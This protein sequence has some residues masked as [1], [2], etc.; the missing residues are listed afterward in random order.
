M[1]YLREIEKSVRKLEYVDWIAEHLEDY[2]FQGDVAAEVREAFVKAAASPNIYYTDC[3][4]A[5]KNMAI[6][7][8]NNPYN[9]FLDIMRWDNC[10]YASDMDGLFI[11]CSIGEADREEIIFVPVGFVKQAG[12]R[13][14]KIAEL[15]T[16]ACEVG[17]EELKK[18]LSNGIASKLKDCRSHMDYMSA[19]QEKEAGTG[20]NRLKCYESRY[21][22]ESVFYVL[23]WPIW[24]LFVNHIEWFTKN[25]KVLLLFPATQFKNTTDDLTA[26]VC[27]NMLF[28]IVALAY[29]LYCT[30]VLFLKGVF[31]S[32]FKKTQAFSAELEESY[33]YLN[34]LYRLLADEKNALNIG[35]FRNPEN[36]FDRLNLIV[37]KA[38][39]R[40]VFLKKFPPNRCIGFLR[41]KLSPMLFDAMAVTLILIRNF[42]AM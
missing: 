16:K 9:E 2:E 10:I 11:P 34:E 3:K 38:R 6:L 23:L 5:C 17:K 7:L 12:V 28:S 15:V 19:L 37:E 25:E 21:N 18:L 8:D 26:S 14:E 32:H 24:L 35:D 31:I 13:P 29:L 39:N 40:I 30:Y 1:E 20:K 42:A 36:H 27:F 41:I 4:N 22:W 33:E